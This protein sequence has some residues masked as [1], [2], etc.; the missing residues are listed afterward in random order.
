MASHA[1]VLARSKISGSLLHRLSR[2]WHGLGPGGSHRD[3]RYGVDCIDAEH[4]QISVL[5]ISP[6]DF[7]VP[8]VRVSCLWKS[9]V[10]VGASVRAI[11]LMVVQRA[12]PEIP[13][14]IEV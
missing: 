13:N 7:V 10:A 12:T 3:Q 9:D 2:P 6:G 4:N 8:I 5:S 11:R 14:F 1:G